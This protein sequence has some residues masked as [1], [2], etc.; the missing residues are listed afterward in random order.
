MR[1]TPKNINEGT[2]IYRYLTELKSTSDGYGG[3]E[4]SLFC[5]NLTPSIY[6]FYYY[7]NSATIWYS[8]RYL[9][10]N[11]TDNEV[12]LRLAQRSNKS[13]LGNEL[14]YNNATMQ[15]NIKGDEY[16]YFAIS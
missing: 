6:Y 1:T 2:D 14:D 11:F 12:E 8:A 15:F 10:I 3:K 13:S 4:N 7:Y 16:Y 5:T 9:K